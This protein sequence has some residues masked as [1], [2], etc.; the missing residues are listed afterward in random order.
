LFFSGQKKVETLSHL[1]K[2]FEKERGQIAREFQ[3]QNEVS[4]FLIRVLG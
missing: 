4:F 1:L 2:E 3:E